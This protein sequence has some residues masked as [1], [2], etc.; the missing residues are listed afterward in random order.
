M[1]ISKAGGTPTG[2]SRTVEETA[3]CVRHR[4]LDAWVGDS[5]AQHSKKGVARRGHSPF[6]YLR[7]GRK[8]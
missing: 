5:E 4:A 8:L 6:W 7:P 3:D 1:K 2:Y